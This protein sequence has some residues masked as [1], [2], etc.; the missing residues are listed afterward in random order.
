MNQTRH[1]QSDDKNDHDETGIFRRRLQD[2]VVG[3]VWVHF[4]KVFTFCCGV[5]VGYVAISVQLANIR[6]AAADNARATAHLERIVE[7]LVTEDRLKSELA[8]RD[9]QIGRLE[10]WQRDVN[11]KAETLTPHGRRK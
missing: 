6:A 3:F 5:I 11:E 9:V 4:W 10:Q 2:Q 7:H 1:S 8:P